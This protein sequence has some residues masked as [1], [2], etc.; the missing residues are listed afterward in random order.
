M[1]EVFV[2]FFRLV[3]RGILMLRQS[4]MIRVVAPWFVAGVVIGE[5]A[6]P[7]IRYMKSWSK[8]RITA[9]CKKR[10]WQWEYLP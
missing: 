1:Q 8:D 4:K 2:E 10:N 9:Y 5:R 3:S 6:A 7:I